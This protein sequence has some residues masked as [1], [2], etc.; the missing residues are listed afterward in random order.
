MTKAYTDTM[1]L[2]RQA[3]HA[4]ILPNSGWEEVAGAQ[5]KELEDLIY[6]K[7]KDFKAKEI[8][9]LANLAKKVATDSIEVI[10]NEPIYALDDGFWMKIR[11]PYVKELSA[12]K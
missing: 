9:K 7:I 5:E 11:E 2:F 8:E 1:T 4:S 6:R 10:I 12:Q 3:T